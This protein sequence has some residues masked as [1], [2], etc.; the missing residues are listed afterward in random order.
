MDEF[1]PSIKP[2]YKDDHFT[3]PTVRELTEAGEIYSFQI[4][5]EQPIIIG[6]EKSQILDLFNYY[7][8]LSC[9]YLGIIKPQIRIIPEELGYFAYNDEN[10][11]IYVSIRIKHISNDLFE[12]RLR[13]QIDSS[14]HNNK[15]LFIFLHEIG[16]A[17]H[18]QKHKSHWNKFKNDYKVNWHYDLEGYMAQQS[19]RIADQIA[20]ILFK[21][22]GLG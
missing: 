12:T 21:R 9:N 17:W 22:Y 7:L 4:N 11:T 19:E 6:K 10:N 14:F 18:Y 3:T 20:V 13:K 15:M 2:W 5:N 16:H 1:K 8:E